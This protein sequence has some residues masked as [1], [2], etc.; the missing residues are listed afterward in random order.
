MKSSVRQGN[1]SFNLIKDLVVK[2]TEYMY[3]IP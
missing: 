2:N 1:V 3:K